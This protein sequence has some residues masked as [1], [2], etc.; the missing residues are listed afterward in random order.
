MRKLK[1]KYIITVICI[2]CT[3]AYILRFRYINNLYP[4]GEYYSFDEGETVTINN[5]E[6]NIISGERISIEEYE[7][8][9]DI[10]FPEYEKILIDSIMLIYI[11][12][13]NKSDIDF[14]IGNLD[15]TFI[16]GEVY[17]G[18]DYF[19][20]SEIN[21]EDFDYTIKAGEE[22]IVGLSA[23]L[24]T[25]WANNIKDD[26]WKLRLTGWPLRLELAIPMKGKI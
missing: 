11:D 5:I 16:N 14:S 23:L 25:D 24:G 15:L 10:E 2:V 22:K 26:E 3:I 12:V 13:N 8:R 21:G 6:Y 18:Y 9:F 17:N 1:K 4:A 19:G 20:L 7:K